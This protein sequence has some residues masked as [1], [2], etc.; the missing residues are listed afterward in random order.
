MDVTARGLYYLSIRTNQLF[1]DGSTR[2]WIYKG[3]LDGRPYPIRWADNDELMTTIS[4]G[5]IGPLTVTDGFMSA[6][7]NPFVGAEY[8]LL[9]ECQR[10]LKIDP[11]STVEN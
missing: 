3:A 6:G 4:F 8:F 11:F 2:S 9:S 5:L 10:R 1:S 7:D